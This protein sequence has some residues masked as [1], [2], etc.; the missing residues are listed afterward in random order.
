[1]KPEIVYVLDVKDDVVTVKKQELKALIDKAY[2]AGK[3]DGAGTITNPRTIDSVTTT[4]G[5]R[6]D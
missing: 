3:K 6:R 1:M 2:E 4:T 5:G